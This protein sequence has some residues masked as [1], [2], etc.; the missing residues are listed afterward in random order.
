M[1]VIESATGS[2]QAQLISTLADLPAPA[3]GSL[4]IIIIITIPIII[5][6][7]I[8]IAIAIGDGVCCTAMATARDRAVLAEQ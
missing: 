4:I 6:I 2:T 1:A 5:T 3:L 7:T 8:T